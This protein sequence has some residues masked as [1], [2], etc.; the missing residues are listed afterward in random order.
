MFLLR[1]S[2]GL[3][4][5]L[6]GTLRNQVTSDARKMVRRPPSWGD[7]AGTI[8]GDP[9]PVLGHYSWSEHNMMQGK[10]VELALAEDNGLDILLLAQRVL[11]LLY[12]MT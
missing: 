11:L 8:Y 4:F 5:D 1:G 10:T 3:I 6:S 12:T 2:S 9:L 7:I